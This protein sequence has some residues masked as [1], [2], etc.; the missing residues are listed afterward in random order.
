MLIQSPDWL[1]TMPKV[2]LHVHL[3]GS[4]SPETLLD[5][6]QR[7]NVDLGISA[8]D[9]AMALYRYHDCQGFIRTFTTCSTCIVTPD[10]LRTL[11]LAHGREMSRQ[12]IR[13]AEIHGNFEPHRRWQGMSMADPLHALNAARDEL[14]AEAE[15]EVCWIADG[16]RDA[17]SEPISATHTVEMMASTGPETSIVALGLGGDEITGPATDFVDA[18]KLAREAGFHV[19]AQ[20]GEVV[21]A[22]SIYDAIT[23]LGAERIGHGIRILEDPDVVT[24]ARNLDISLEISITS[25]VMTG[26]VADDTIHYLPEIAASGLAFSINTDDPPMF[27]T[28]LDREYAISMHVLGLD[29]QGVAWL[30]ASG[31]D[32]SFAS[33]ST[34]ERLHRELSAHTPLDQAIGD[35]ASINAT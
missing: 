8:R 23:L 15:I 4:M 11:V 6:S 28:D 10:D 19:V 32:Q 29:R 7:N 31:I 13:Y 22:K 24:L 26:V 2:E 9:D 27:H 21:G 18:F 17:D 34:R 20:A 25:N 14:F 1:V 33:P 35:A 3:E 16:I 30:V 5:L 12:N